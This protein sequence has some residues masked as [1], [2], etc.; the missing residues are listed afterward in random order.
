M[1]SERK[2]ESR[3]MRWNLNWISWDMGG[4]SRREDE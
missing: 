2:L 1:R 4:V 3:V